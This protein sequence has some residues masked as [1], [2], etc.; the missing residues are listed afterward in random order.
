MLRKIIVSAF[1]IVFSA[2]V[3]SAP[4]D[5]STWS[6]DNRFDFPGGQGAG[7][8]NVAS[9]GSSVVQTVN[10]D[11]T[12]FL[13]PD[14][15]SNTTVKGTFYENSGD[16]DFVGFVF[17]FNSTNSTM[18]LFDWKQAT[19]SAYGLAQRGITLKR[20]DAAPTTRDHLWTTASIPGIMTQ[21]YYEDVQRINGR[22]YEFELTF[23]SPTISIIL[24]D[25]ATNAVI[26][27]FSVS[28]SLYS[29]G[30]F[31]FYNFSE[32]NVTYTSFTSD[33]EPPFC[34]QF[35]DDPR[36]T[37]QVPVPAPLLL[38]ALGLAGI[39]YQRHQQVRAA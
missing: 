6:T 23:T 30:Q 4:V 18:Y 34:E 1:G 25:L 7:I 8:W 38:M 15:Y 14:N 22:Q 37:G 39:G 3:L 32:D 11:S 26:A 9:D 31:G 13:S 17:G 33:P 28:D 20:F 10:G 24:T 21:L 16:D 12:M 36:C 5:L 27:N 29:T 19:Q 2:S 35:P